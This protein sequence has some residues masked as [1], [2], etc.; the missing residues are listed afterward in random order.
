MKNNRSKKAFTLIELL[1]VVL[2]ITI[3]AA[4]ALPQY[5]KAVVK[6]RY[7]TLKNLTRSLADAEERYYLENYAY[8]TQVENLDIDFQQTPLRIL[9]QQ[10]G[11]N[12]IY[13]FDWGFCNVIVGLDDYP[14]VACT[15]GIP[16]K[17]NKQSAVLLNIFQLLLRAPIAESK[18]VRPLAGVFLCTKFVSKKQ[19]V[20]L[21]ILRMIITIKNKILDK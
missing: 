18:H 15:L 2:I 20:L 1:V 9:D 3:L 19:N 5:R 10:S 16:G 14:R 8:N 11:K 12:R 7:S 13:L 4:V 17:Y 6:S 21:L